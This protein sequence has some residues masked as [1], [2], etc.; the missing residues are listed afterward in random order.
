MTD[1]V[2]RF[3]AKWVPEV[4]TGCWLWTG[5]C[6]LYGYGLIRPG[7]ATQRPEGAHRISWKLHR[8]EIPEGMSVLHK[9]DVPGCVNPEHLFLGT[10]K[11]NTQ[12]MMRKGR[13]RVRNGE[14]H[15][16]A[17]LTNTQVR[18]IRGDRRSDREIA[19]EYGVWPSRIYDI[20]TGKGWRHL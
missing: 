9:C 6:H 7:P 8:G 10:I 3:N 5:A 14:S 18:S 1:I 16:R 15:P 11:D 13:H 17:K 4:W 20:K 2:E 19:R 12:D